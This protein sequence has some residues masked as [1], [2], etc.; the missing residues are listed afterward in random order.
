MREA[1]EVEEMAAQP[2]DR[3][4]RGY[5]AQERSRE[6]DRRVR[7]RVVALGRLGRRLFGLNREEVS[8]SV[9]VKP[10][11][12]A[13]WSSNWKNDRLRALPRGRTCRVLPGRSKSRAAA[14]VFSAWFSC[15]M[16]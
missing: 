13:D 15:S 5:T 10:C 2:K 7:K 16:P 11:T 12:L 9:G 3:T 1:I 6:L 8:R 4:V 14:P